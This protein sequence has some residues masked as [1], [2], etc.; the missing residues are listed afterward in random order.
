[1]WTRPV[2]RTI[3]R[4]PQSPG[5]PGYRPPDPSLVST[6]SIIELLNGRRSLTTSRQARLDSEDSARTGRSL[7]CVGDSTLVQQPCVAIVGT[8][9]ASPDGLARARRLARE[10][11]A[12]EIVV[13]SGLARGVDTA[14]LA[15]AVEAGG[16][17]IS[18]IGTPVDR[19]YPAENAALQERIYREHLLI[20]PFSPGSRVYPSNFPGRN[21][22]MAALSD[23]TV[24]IE[25]GESSGTLHQATE[26]VRLGRPL[27]IAQSVIDD[28]TLDWPNTFL[29]HPHVRA[30]RTVAD[31]MQAL[32]SSR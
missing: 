13:V 2:G 30:L 1:M 22:V 32:S 31:V 8:R 17:V 6:V 20:S 27:L 14:A 4:S 9:E 7:W 24:I 26:C 21:K 10:L 3:A 28:P 11:A 16:R 19:A 12:R 23:V 15:A 29:R 25:A 5:N 18:V